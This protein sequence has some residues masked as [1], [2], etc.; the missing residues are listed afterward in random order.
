MESDAW[1]QVTSRRRLPASK[2]VAREHCTKFDVVGVF[3]ASARGDHGASSLIKVRPYTHFDNN[4]VAIL[5][6]EM[7]QHYQVP[8]P[9]RDIIL[10][11]LSGL[12]AGVEILLAEAVSV[13][14]FAMFST[15]YPGPGLKPGFFVK[16]LFV[17]RSFRG[18]GAGSALMRAVARIA[19]HRGHPRVDWTADGDNARLL[20]FYENLGALAQQQKVFF[21][22][23][24][25]ALAA[26]GASTQG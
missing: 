16:E 24:G 15:T 9:P 8:C 26:L 21:R 20:G 5:I 19:V 18:G 6:E 10:N 4:A 3:V 13:I 1:R 23:S 2:D 22:L 17:S 12:P 14:G 11:S 7:Q 25:E